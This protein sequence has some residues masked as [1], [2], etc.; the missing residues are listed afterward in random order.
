MTN[1]MTQQQTEAI[2]DACY[3][4]ISTGVWMDAQG[5]YPNQGVCIYDALTRL[6]SVVDG[7]EY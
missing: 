2:N 6:D 4:M 5:R 7:S 3:T 1:Q